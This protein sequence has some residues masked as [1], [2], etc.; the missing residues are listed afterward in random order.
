VVLAEL[1]LVELFALLDTEE[2][3]SELFTHCVMD[4]L[5]LVPLLALDLVCMR[6]LSFQRDRA[7]LPTPDTPIANICSNQIDVDQV[8]LP[9]CL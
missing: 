8:V 5:M 9:L 7:S 3:T 6:A 4:L 2:E 1:L